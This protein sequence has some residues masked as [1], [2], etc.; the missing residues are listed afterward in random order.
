MKGAIIAGQTTGEALF[1]IGIFLMSIGV[2]GAFVYYLVT[3]P[4]RLAEL[5]TWTRS[6]NILLQGVIWLL[7]LPWMIALAFWVAPWWMPIRLVLV[8]GAL[9]WTEW[10]L[11]PWK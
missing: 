1:S 3:D 11:W 8:I 7:F 5:W 9:G 10:L 6:L 2:T 4:S